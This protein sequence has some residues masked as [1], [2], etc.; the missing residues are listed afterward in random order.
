MSDMF[1]K[2]SGIFPKMLCKDA[3]FLLSHKCVQMHKNQ[4]NDPQIKFGGHFLSLFMFMKF[5]FKLE[6]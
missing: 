2:M 5:V 1:S 4:W 3:R 6:V